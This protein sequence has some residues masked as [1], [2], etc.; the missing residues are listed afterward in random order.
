LL[1]VGAKV[2]LNNIFFDF[3]KATLRAASDLELE[4]LLKF[5]EQ[6]PVIVVDISG[7]TDSKGNDEYNLKLS[8]ERAQAVVKY[9]T[10]K[11]VAA[12]RMVAKGYGETYPSALNENKDGSDN[13]EGRQ[14]NRRV[15]LKITGI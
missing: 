2:V 14:L 8:Q 5:L 13:P 12:I 6:H 7:F 1:V 9:F 10:D 3:D 4:K 11:G 15:E